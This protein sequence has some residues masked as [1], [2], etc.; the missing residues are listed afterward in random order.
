MKKESLLLLPLLVLIVFILIRGHGI[1]EQPPTQQQIDL[2]SITDRSLIDATLSGKQFQFEVVNSYASQLLGLSNREEIGSDGML[3]VFHRPDKHQIW[4]KDMKFD[5]DLIWLLENRVVDLS[6][7]V[8]KPEPGQEP[9]ALPIYQ[10][11]QRVDMLLEVVAGFVDRYQ[12]EVG[13]ELVVV[14]Y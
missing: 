2:A 1:K 9:D 6:L 13:D 14:N 12:I 3:F 10:P 4:M 5:L 8:P 7:A 11:T